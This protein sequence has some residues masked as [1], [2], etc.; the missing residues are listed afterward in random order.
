M[1]MELHL[2]ECFAGLVTENHIQ[3]P[4]KLQ[5]QLCN[6]YCNFANTDLNNAV[7]LAATVYLYIAVK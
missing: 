1:Y 5:F 7:L 6:W 2:E 4:N 3:H